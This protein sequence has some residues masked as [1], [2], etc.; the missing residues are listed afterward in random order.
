MKTYWA[1]KDKESGEYLDEW[2]ER[3]ERDIERLPELFANKKDA[4]A[5]YR[6]GEKVVKVK[7]VEVKK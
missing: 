7:I 4:I 2:G 3:S 6:R 1:I 5:E